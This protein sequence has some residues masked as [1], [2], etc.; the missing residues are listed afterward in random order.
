M[1]YINHDDEPSVQV[2][3]SVR[4]KVIK[5]SLRTEILW[6]LLWRLIKNRHA[7]TAHTVSGLPDDN[8]HPQCACG[9]AS[10]VKTS[11]LFL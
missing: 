10:G 8:R 11:Y 7:T 4:P 2:D 3:F 5:K 9:C 6:T 1:I